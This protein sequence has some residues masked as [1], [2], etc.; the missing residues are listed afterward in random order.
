MELDLEKTESVRNFVEEYKKDHKS[1]NILVLNAGTAMKGTN[2]GDDGI[3]VTFKVNYLSQ[4]YLTQLL[5]PLLLESKNGRV[6]CL[7]SVAHRNAS[8]KFNS[9]CHAEL[10]DC[11]SESKLAMVYL[12]IIYRH[13]LQEN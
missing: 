6:V 13:V 8:G 2:K 9:A 11:Y 10:K 4:F 12:L 1:L 7:S 5:K 3:S